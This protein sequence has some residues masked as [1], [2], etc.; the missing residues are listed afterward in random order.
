MNQLSDLAAS[1]ERIPFWLVLMGVSAVLW[2]AFAKL[3]VPPIIE[4]AYC[5]E[6]S[7]FSTASS[8]GTSFIRSNF[9]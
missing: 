8:K 2:I 5:G 7:H 9:T 4:S 1:A 3:V 6:V